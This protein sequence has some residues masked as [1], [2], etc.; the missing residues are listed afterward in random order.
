VCLNVVCEVIGCKCA[1]ERWSFDAGTASTRGII[2]RGPRLSMLPPDGRHHNS[3]RGYVTIWRAI[4][5]SGCTTVNG[6]HDAAARK[7]RQ[8]GRL[9][10]LGGSGSGHNRELERTSPSSADRFTRPAS[11]LELLCYAIP[12]TSLREPIGF[13]HRRRH[14]L[15]AR[16]LHSRD[17]SYTIIIIIIY[18]MNLLFR[19]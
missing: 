14:F 11:D 15:L 16:P 10:S 3:L 7:T 9:V 1:G 8:P 2:Y 4:T 12:S 13:R 5:S 6:T 19:W 17:R 18:E